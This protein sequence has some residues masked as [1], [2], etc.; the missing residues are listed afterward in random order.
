MPKIV[1][2]FESS[3]LVE[4]GVFI[5]R[6]ETEILVEEAIK[7]I[8]ERIKEKKNKYCSKKEKFVVVDACTG[9][10]CI[11]ISIAKK[12]K[13]L[14][15]GELVFIGTDIDIKSLKNAQKNAEDLKTY[16]VKTDLVE[17]IKYADVIV[18]NPPYVSQK[19]KCKIKVDDPDQAI[20]GGEI[21][22]ETTIKLIEQSSEILRE[23]GLLIFETGYDDLRFF[24]MTEILEEY[25]NAILKTAERLN[26]SILKIVKDY[27]KIERIMIF[28]KK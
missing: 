24:G 27:G 22:Y 1:D 12:F 14:N 26:F 21:G 17:S 10:G 4:D 7:T 23:E 11:I 28:Q 5:P 8:Q 6:P 20:F 18:S 15:T 19:V 2:F 13:N 9:C 3:F 25:K 16:F